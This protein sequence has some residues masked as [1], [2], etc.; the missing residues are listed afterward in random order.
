MTLTRTATYSERVIRK[1]T[2]ALYSTFRAIETGD[3]TVYE[4]PG[5]RHDHPGSSFPAYDN[6][7]KDRID[8]RL[9]ICLVAC[10]ALP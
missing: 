4:F 6:Y 3:F 7:M 10:E 2:S 1:C 8:R 9:I 5:K